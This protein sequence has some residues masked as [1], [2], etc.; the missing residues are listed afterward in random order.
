M[1]YKHKLSL[2]GAGFHLFCLTFLLIG[3][4]LPSQNGLGLSA[5]PSVP[6][7][8][9]PTNQKPKELISNTVD[10]IVRIVAEYPDKSQTILRR[11]KLTT[12]I[13]PHFDFK[14]M[15]KRSLG[16]HWNNITEAQQ[17]EFVEI[18]SDLLSRTYLSYLETVK[19][20]MVKVLSEEIKPSTTTGSFAVAVVKTDVKHKG[21]VFPIHYKLVERSAGWKVYDI[22]IENIGL[23][24]NYR[25][26]F[27]GVLR[28]SGF[29]G[30]IEKLKAKEKKK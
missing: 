28:K 9:S 19:P 8:S 26:E 12:L 5:P 22:V 3:G 17:S 29:D 24:S 13:E 2:P 7:T 11:E 18:F 16:S 27:A 23:V 6:Q 10:G 15:S 4:I 21:E 30:L 25:S 20:G 1:I 14:E